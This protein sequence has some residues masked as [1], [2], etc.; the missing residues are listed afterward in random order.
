VRVCVCVCV[1]VCVAQVLREAEIID[2]L[3][4]ILSVKII[5]YSS[6]VTSTDGS[7]VLDAVAESTDGDDGEASDG[8]VRDYTVRRV[9]RAVDL[10]VSRS[11]TL[12]QLYQAILVAF[13]HL[14]EVPTPSLVMPIAASTTLSTATTTTSPSITSQ[15]TS[16][17]NQEVR[18]ESLE[19]IEK[20]LLSIAKGFS[21]GAPL[22]L[23]TSLKSAWDPLGMV[24]SPD[25]KIDH[26]VFGFR[27]GVI[28]LVRGAA[29][30]QRAVLQD[31]SLLQGFEG[32]AVQKAPPARP[33]MK[34]LGSWKSKSSGGVR[35]ARAE[36]ALSLGDQPISREEP[37]ARPD[38]S[39][40]NS[41]ADLGVKCS[42]VSMAEIDTEGLTAIG[43][44]S[45]KPDITLVE[46]STST[47]LTK[48]S[49]LPLLLP[50]V[51]QQL[52]DVKGPP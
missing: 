3:D 7:Q 8:C 52:S 5:T 48:C 9:H 15:T 13:P 6:P 29:D 21:S 35:M 44:M 4:W 38:R 28:L 30:W 40:L 32:A 25:L 37:P 19:F 49:S 16:E 47:E 33:V 18:E 20:S 46:N 41:I 10:P 34:P 11:A 42:D 27:D 23:Q 17:Q 1:C 51:A 26:P 43:T 45:L 22:T 14:R 50:S 24:S 36:K 39:E 2:P 31:P 12:R